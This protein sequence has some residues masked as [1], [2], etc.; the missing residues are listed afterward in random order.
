MSNELRF[1]FR[2]LLK[3]PGFTLVVV[4]TL[5]LG[6]CASDPATFIGIAFLLITVAFIAC[7]SPARRALAVDAITPLRSE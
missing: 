1:P 2:M 7:L 5:V 6:I 4:F 3:K